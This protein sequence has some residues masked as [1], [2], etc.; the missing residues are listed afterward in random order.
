MEGLQGDNGDGG[1][2][3]VYDKDKMQEKE[4]E[5]RRNSLYEK[6]LHKQ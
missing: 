2:R 4:A 3:R 1:V 5:T 6:G